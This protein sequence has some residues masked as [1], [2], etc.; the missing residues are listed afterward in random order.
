MYSIVLTLHSLLR[1]F[2]LIFG[3]LAVVRAVSGW[4]GGRPWT[5]ADNRAGLLFTIFLDV[6]ILLGL[7]LYFA[8]S[9]FG[10]VVF[11][12]FATA[13]RTPQLRFWAVEHVTMMLLGAVVAHVGRVLIRKSP[14]DAT[15]HRRAALFFAAALLL[16]IAGIPWP[17]SANAR[18]LFRL[19]I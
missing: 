10:S 5:G 15:R 9:Q 6:Q 14:A 7:L 18:P 19:G 12:D 4:T 8:L 2:V 16:I 17:G 1:W 13:M 11:H 3:L